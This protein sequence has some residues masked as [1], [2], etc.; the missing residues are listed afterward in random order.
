MTTPQSSIPAVGPRIE[1]GDGFVH[2]QDFIIQDPELANS[3]RGLPRE[4]QIQMMESIL[5]RGVETQR[6]MNTTAA[7]ESLEKV[8][9]KISNDIEEKRKSLVDGV[10][11]IAEQIVAK[12]GD[13]SMPEMLA[14]WRDSFKTLLD[15]QFDPLN[16][17]SILTKFDTMIENKSKS[18]NSEISNKLDFNI[19]TST[20]NLLQKNIKEHLTTEITSF[21][22]KFEEV[23]RA[24]GID[25]AV[26]DQKKL[27]ANRGNVFEDVFYDIICELA[28]EKN[29]TA[30]NP[31]KRK[32]SG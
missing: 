32:A 4:L 28:R 22:E 25:T 29:D 30:D 31:G 10:H 23:T 20:I 3:L 16:T 15:N 17:E 21:K 5:S 14:T 9:L 13:L 18:Q 26:E 7:A 24:L 1:V 12:K 19:E 2:I 27:Q 8:A 11:G 6:L